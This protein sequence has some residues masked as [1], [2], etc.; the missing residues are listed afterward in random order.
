M[1]TDI[2]QF[3]DNVR[4]YQSGALNWFVMVTIPIMFFTF[5]GWYGFHWWAARK[6]RL[7][8]TWDADSEKQNGADSSYVSGP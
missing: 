1:S 4:E 6:D 5:L 2:I 7:A 8:S 3:Q